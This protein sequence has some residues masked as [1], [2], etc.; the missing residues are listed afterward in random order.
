METDFGR[1]LR[2]VGISKILCLLILLYT[3]SCSSFRLFTPQPEDEEF[4]I[5]RKYVG[6]FLDYRQTGPDDL[7]G[8]N[9]IWIK[10]SMEDQYGKISAY[11]KKCDFTVGERLFLRRTLYDPGIGAGFW[12]YTIENDSAVSYKATDFQYD[13][14]VLTETIF[15]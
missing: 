1:I 8:P 6:V 3:A 7:A 10:T 2:G 5:S 4:F 13:H 12:E 11:G 15:N 9:L 14:K